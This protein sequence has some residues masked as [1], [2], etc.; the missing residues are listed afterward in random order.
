MYTSL[1][2]LSPEASTEP[3][4]CTVIVACFFEARRD[5]VSTDHRTGFIDVLPGGDLRLQAIRPLRG[6]TVLQAGLEPRDLALDRGARAAIA[7][8][9]RSISGSSALLRKAKKP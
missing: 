6:I 3:S 4:G 7:G 9:G 2:G 1:F 5:G 8:S